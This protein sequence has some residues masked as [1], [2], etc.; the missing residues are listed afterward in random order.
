VSAHNYVLRQWLREGGTSNVHRR[1]D[2]ALGTLAGRFPE[3]L[4]TQGG[5]AQSER[6]DEVMVLMLR[7][8]TPQ[9]RI[10]REIEAATRKDRK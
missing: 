6:P 8:D 9:W 4:Q 5:A 3:W 10:A 1:F 7:P 2:A